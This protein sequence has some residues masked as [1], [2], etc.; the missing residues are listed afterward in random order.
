MTALINYADL[1]YPKFNIITTYAIH[2]KFI[3]ESLRRY[4]FICTYIYYF[5]FNIK[6]F[7]KKYTDFTTIAKAKHKIQSEG[8]V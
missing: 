3:W 1:C 5:L 8:G 4:L 2:D 6:T 7:Y